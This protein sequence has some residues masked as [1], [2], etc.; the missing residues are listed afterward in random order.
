MASAVLGT[1]LLAACLSAESSSKNALY[2][3]LAELGA[4]LEFIRGM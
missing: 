2:Y 3:M 4:G 1:L